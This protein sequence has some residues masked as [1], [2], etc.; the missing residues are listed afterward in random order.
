MNTLVKHF[1]RAAVIANL[2]DLV[3]NWWSARKVMDLYMGVR[4]FFALPCLTYDKRRRYET[5]SLMTYFNVLMKS[6]GHCLE[7]NY[8]SVSWWNGLYSWE[9]IFIRIILT[10]NAFKINLRKQFIEC[11]GKTQETGKKE[12]LPSPFNHIQSSWPAVLLCP[13]NIV[14]WIRQ[15]LLFTSVC[16][17]QPFSC[18]LDNSGIFDVQ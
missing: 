4:H 13:P 15:Y 7:S 8:G 6:K 12:S 17:P 1:M 10:F 2:N 18:G 16:A 14:L 5:I 9:R 11:L 3:V